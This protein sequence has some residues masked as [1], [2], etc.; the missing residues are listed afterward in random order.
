MQFVRP[1][2]LYLLTLVP[3]AA[4]VALWAAR[5][6]RADMARL[7]TPA[8][9]DA[10]SGSVSHTRR[11]WKTGLWFV[12][13]LALVVALARPLWGTEV[14]VIAQRGVQVM[15]VLDVSTSM[16]AEDVKPNRLERAKLV[17]EELMVRLGGHEIGLVLFSGAAFVQFPLTSDM[18][19]TR[20]FLRAAGPASISR[21][22]T[23]LDEAIR[24]AVQG[25]PENSASQRVILL[26][27]DGEGHQQGDVLAAARAA[28]DAGV[29]IH[30][31]GFGSSEGEPIPI[32]DED[33]NLIGYKK[34]AQGE[35]VLSRLDETTLRAITEQTGGMFLSFGAAGDE[36]DAVADAIS[37]LQH[38]EAED[39]F[40][41][42]GVERYGW[43]AALALMALV[44]EHLVGERKSRAQ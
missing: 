43:F 22:G 25:F 2:Y 40:E 44:A 4:V 38:G 14:R 7:G 20:S 39:Q 16:N 36:I 10:L 35:T 29:I 8:L 42:R 3:L 9:I 17:I 26:L 15:A 28:A 41:T 19:T 11:R 1:D 34:D 24:V 23:A 33:G 37:A 30:A 18:N 31:I 6:R 12:A 5:R 21:P 27:T 32:R 13:L